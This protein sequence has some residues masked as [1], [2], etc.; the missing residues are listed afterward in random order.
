MF[1]AIPF[2]FYAVFSRSLPVASQI[3][4]QIAGPLPLSPLRTLGALI[5]VTRRVLH[6]LPAS[7]RVELPRL[8]LKSR[9]GFPVASQQHDVKV[10]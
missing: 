8:R 9:V 1:F 3:R 6:F 2:I 4:G 10:R 5:L 7:T